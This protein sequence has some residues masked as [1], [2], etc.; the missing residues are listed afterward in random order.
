MTLLSAEVV[1][2]EEVSPLKD[3]PYPC[4]NTRVPTPTSQLPN[5][6]F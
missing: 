3:M 6:Y 1:A 4:R 5:P 2:I